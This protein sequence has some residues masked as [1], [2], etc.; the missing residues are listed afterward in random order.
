MKLPYF[1]VAVLLL[2]CQSLFAET[3]VLNDPTRMTPT[4]EQ[5]LAGVLRQVDKNQ[6]TLSDNA[7]KSEIEDPTRMNQNFREAL[8]RVS[9]ANGAAGTAGAG[10]V[11]AVPV[12]PDMKLVASV[13]GMHKEKNHVMLQINGRTEMVGIGD[14]ITTIKG[15]QLM[16]IQV[17]E[18]DGLHVK[19]VVQP[20]N[21]T[22]ILR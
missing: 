5:G 15:A 3:P 18:I 12:L 14:K 10:A 22:V 2:C 13:C 21:E 8:K 9:S 11:A 17:L 6:A 7:S 19:V 16:E 1:K 20:A 4:L